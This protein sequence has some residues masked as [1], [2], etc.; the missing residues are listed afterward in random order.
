[1]NQFEKDKI[2]YLL[3]NDNFVKHFAHEYDKLE[4]EQCR[5]YIKIRVKKIPYKYYL[6]F[7]KR[8]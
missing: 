2:S 4:I 3:A 1:M 8:F 6:L 5:R 7:S